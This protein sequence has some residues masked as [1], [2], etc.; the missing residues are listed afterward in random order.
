MIAWALKKAAGLVA[1]LPPGVATASARHW[2]WF[3]AHVVRLRR[4]YVLATLARCFPEK[5]V[6][7]RR[8]IYAG[9]YTQQALNVMELMR[10]A[11]GQDAELGAKLETH[12]E[13]VVQA[14]LARG[15][16]ALIML[17]HFRNYDLMGLYAATL[18]R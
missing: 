12:G 4:R 11:G 8:A 10:F 9:M 5:P 15:H 13:E 7:E 6:A 18:F 3:L 2:G 14:A 17:A 1:A 16:G